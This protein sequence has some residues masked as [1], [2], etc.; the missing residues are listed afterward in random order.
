MHNEV[1]QFLFQI[2]FHYGLF[3]DTKYSSLCH[4]AGPCL[5]ILYVL[6][7]SANPKLPGFPHGSVVKNP[8][9]KQETFDPWVGK[10][11]WRREWQPTPVFLPEKSHG[12]RILAGYSPWG[13]QELDRT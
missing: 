11:P 2:L 13:H 8:P 5:S 7:A 10:I 9:A 12:Q 1:I 3:Q 6:F 4:T